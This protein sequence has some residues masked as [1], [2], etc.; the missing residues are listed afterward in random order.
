MEDKKRINIA[1]SCNERY[2]RFVFVNLANISN[3]LGAKYDVNFYLIQSEIS[4][5]TIKK[6][7]NFSKNLNLKFHNIK[8]EDDAFLQHVANHSRAPDC[9]RFYDGACHLFLPDNIDRI[10]YID[11]GDV[12]IL[13]DDYD[14]YFE[15]FNNKS[16][17]VTTYWKLQENKWDFDKFSGMWGG[18]NSGHMLVNLKKLREDGVVRS[19]YINYVNSWKNHFP[20]KDVL[21][22]GDQAFLTAFF[23]GD[24]ETIEKPNPYNIKVVAL[25]G[26]KPELEFKSIHLNG[27]F[28]NIKPWQI[29]FE[30]FNDLKSLRIFVENAKDDKKK[31]VFFSEIECRYLFKWWEF[32]KETPV[33]EELKSESRSNNRLLALFARHIRDCASK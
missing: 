27:L 11:T 5:D 22:G 9:Q 32:C 24:I 26:V 4:Y 6:L 15:E 10:L 1:T 16:L 12:L 18:F 33:Y 25:N 13:S 20:D 7:E 28:G 21:F 23:A 29:P 19:D 3:V 8:V 17:L 30:D 14:F 31:D 2:A